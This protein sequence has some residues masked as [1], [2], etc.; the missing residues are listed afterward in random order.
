MGDQFLISTN[1]DLLKQALSENG[2]AS[3]SLARVESIA[4]HSSVL[5]Q[6]AGPEW[7]TLENLSRLVATYF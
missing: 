5:V 6:T 4:P 7:A 3:L 2:L 1:P